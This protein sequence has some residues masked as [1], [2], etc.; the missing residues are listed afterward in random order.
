[1]C[2]PKEIVSSHGGVAGRQFCSTTAGLV[3][4]LRPG[5]SEG[6][7]SPQIAILAGRIMI[8]PWSWGLPNFQ[9]QLIYWNTWLCVAPGLIRL[10]SLSF[11]ND[12]LGDVFLQKTYQW[13]QQWNNF[14]TRVTSWLSTA[15]PRWAVMAVRLS[16]PA[17]ISAGVDQHNFNWDLFG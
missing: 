15:L 11:Q 12:A 2:L 5:M 1:M 8:N 3:E 17:E 14:P 10:T 9:T 16:S 4:D 6:R 7:V 13:R